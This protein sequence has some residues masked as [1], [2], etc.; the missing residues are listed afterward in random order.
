[1]KSFNSMVLITSNI[2]KVFWWLHHYMYFIS[3]NNGVMTNFEGEL[4]FEFEE[5]SPSLPPKY[6]DECGVGGLNC[7]PCL[8]KPLVIVTLCL[9]F[10]FY[11]PSMVNLNLKLGIQIRT[12]D[13]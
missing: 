11:A 13:N 3:H 6:N 12:F 9:V 5:S 10:R 8:V 1:M 7:T 2:D 4:I